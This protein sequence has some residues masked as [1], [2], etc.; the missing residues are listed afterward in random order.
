MSPK[1]PMVE[2]RSPHDLLLSLG[3][4]LVEDAWMSNGRYTYVH[5]E[6]A[7]RTYVLKIARILK[8]KGWTLDP[9]SLRAFRHPVTQHM[10]ELEPGGSG[11]TG[12]FLHHMNTTSGYRAA[13]NDENARAVGYA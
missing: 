8:E 7:S 12:H 1:Q 9:R 4:K 13:G 11:A 2:A 10:M 5:D 6:D 3:Y